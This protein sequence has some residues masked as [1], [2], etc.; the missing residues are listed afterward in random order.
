M[1]VRDSRA[2]GAVNRAPCPCWETHCW[3]PFKQ[4]RNSQQ[5]QLRW[6]KRRGGTLFNFRFPRFKAQKTQYLHLFPPSSSCFFPRSPDVLSWCAARCSLLLVVSWASQSDPGKA[7]CTQ[8]CCVSSR[9]IMAQVSRYHPATISSVLLR[10]FTQRQQV[11]VYIGNINW[12]S[13]YNTCPMNRGGEEGFQCR[14]SSSVAKRR[15]RT[16]GATAEF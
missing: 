2:K 14:E 4:Q 13:N 10:E 3:E 9:L 12:L 15:K 11:A 7:G 5:S 1:Q 16:S 6:T 8:R